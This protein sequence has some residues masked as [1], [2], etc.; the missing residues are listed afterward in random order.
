MR[1]VHD[2]ET[3][4]AA[5]A[6]LLAGQ[7]VGEVARE[8][9]LPHNTVSRWR[10]EARAE[11]GRSDDIGELLLDYLRENLVTLRE[12]QIVFR[13]SAWLRA[14]GAADVAVLHGVL[15]DKAVRLLEALDG[16]GV[17]REAPSKVRRLYG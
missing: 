15:T 1:K 11:A 8:Y 2:P 17:Q 4:A 10:T 7:S 16:S 6:A 14:Q 12:Q 13:D 3:R 9:R 5:T